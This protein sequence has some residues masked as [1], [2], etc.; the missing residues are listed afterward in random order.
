MQWD[1]MTHPDSCRP[2]GGFQQMLQSQKRFEFNPEFWDMR[3]GMKELKEGDTV[4]AA[5]LS[6]DGIFLTFFSPF[7]RNTYFNIFNIL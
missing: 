3:W 5:C 7:F 4:M 1:V 6:P 2:A